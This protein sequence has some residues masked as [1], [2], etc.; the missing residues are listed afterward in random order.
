[1]LLQRYDAWHEPYSSCIQRLQRVLQPLPIHV[2]RGERVWLIVQR[3]LPIISQ[4]KKN[5]IQPSR[6]IKIKFK[7]TC[8]FNWR[9]NAAS[10][11]LDLSNCSWSNKTFFWSS[12]HWITISFTVRSFFLKILIV[13]AWFLFSES[14]SS[15]ISRTRD[16]NLEIARRAPTTAFASTSS[17]RTDKFYENF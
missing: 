9:L 2:V 6:L 12:S 11:P 13:S 10:F 17:R 4:I 7:I 14:N 15:S 1:M 5:L 16:S 3:I 8:S